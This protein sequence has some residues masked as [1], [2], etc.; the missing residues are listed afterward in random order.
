MKRAFIVLAVL[1]ALQGGKRPMLAADFPAVTIVTEELPPYNYTE[2]GQIVGSSTDVV[3]AVLDDI[4]IPAKFIALPW[5]RAMK[6]AQEQSNVLIYSISYTPSRRE[7]FKWVGL[8]NSGAEFLYCLRSKPI[9]LTS[10]DQAKNFRV[11]TVARDFRIEYL[12][13]KGFIEGKNIDSAHS[14]QANYAKL[15]AGRIDLWPIDS[16]VMNNVVRAA[17]DDPTTMLMP[18]M[19]MTELE[20]QTDFGMAFGLKTPDDVVARFRVGLQHIKE[21]GRFAAI[22]RKWHEAKD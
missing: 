6:M 3:R 13:S 17:G 22:M 4:Q 16:A 14:H 15:K 21:N 1:V 9:V 5:A 18:V 11:G 20:A 19:E 10:L 7:Q 8:I 12:L 2:N